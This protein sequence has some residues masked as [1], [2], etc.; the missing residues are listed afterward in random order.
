MLDLAAA[1]SRTE[2][3]AA[4][5]GYWRI[6]TQSTAMSLLVLAETDYPGWTVT[7]DGQPAQSLRAYTTLRAVCVPAGD[8]E[9][10]WQYAP[11]VYYI[12]GLVTGIALLIML[13]SL[14]LWLGNRGAGKV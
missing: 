11:T 9:V 5:P 12:G 7:V 4:E 8:H 2:I 3:V 10:I 6:Q 1:D 13:L 14:Y